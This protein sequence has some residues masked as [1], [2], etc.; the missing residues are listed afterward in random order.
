MRKPLQAA[1]AVILSFSLAVAVPLQ[2]FAADK[3]I[4]AKALQTSL[5]AKVGNPDLGKQYK[6]WCLAFVADQFAEM[7]AVRSSACC[8]AEYGRLRGAEGSILTI[9][10]V[11]IGSD[12]FF[13]SEST[14]CSTC[15]N[16]YGNG[17]E[18]W[19]AGHVG[20]YVGGGYVIHAMNNRIAKDKVVTLHNFK[21]MDYVGYA[22]HG[23]V[24][25]KADVAATT[26]GTAPEYPSVGSVPNYL[27]PGY[28]PPT[29]DEANPSPVEGT[30]P[31]APS[32]PAEEPAAPAP[33]PATVKNPTAPKWKSLKTAKKRVIKVAWKKVAGVTGY[34][35]QYAANKQFKLSLTKTVKASATSVSLKARYAKKRYY[36]RVRA[37]KTVSGK[38]YYSKWTAVKSVTTK[39]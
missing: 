2:A 28:T 1:L 3:T 33:K 25:M 37:Y 27:P 7:G 17:T 36:V 31:V 15:T 30:P 16:K 6:S 5:N 23:G 22:A 4:S 32:E 13:T 20:I 8:A 21:S 19:Y 14:V 38:K 39:S 18:K 10:S 34:Q 35:V 9:N 29:T 11:P 24:K 12:V 26:H